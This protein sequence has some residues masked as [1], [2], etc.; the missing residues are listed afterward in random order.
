MIFPILISYK[1]ISI[2][3]R[4]V[5]IETGYKPNFSSPATLGDLGEICG[6][7]LEISSKAICGIGFGFVVSFLTII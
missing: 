3:G 4:P 2:V 7:S 5:Y 6:K 1:G